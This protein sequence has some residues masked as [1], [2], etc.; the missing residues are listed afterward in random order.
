MD[1]TIYYILSQIFIIINYALLIITYQL[2]SKKNI[3]LFNGIG[4][5]ATAIS[6]ALLSAWSGVATSIIAL[7]RNVIFIYNEKNCKN[8]S[9]VDYKDIV[10]L[11][12]VY[13]VLLLSLLITYTNIWSVLPVLTTMVYTYSIWQKDIKIYSILGVAVSVLSITYSIYIFSLCGVLLESI[14]LISSIIGIIKKMEK[15]EK[16]TSKKYLC[17]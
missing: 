17:A 9:N 8:E 16:K 13:L 1:I 12:I 7:I 6:F 11:I 4:L 3:I 2:K 15:S 14:M 10:V 5:I